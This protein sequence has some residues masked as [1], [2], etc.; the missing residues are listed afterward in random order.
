[1]YLW[2]TDALATELKQ[3][4]L[5]QREQF[6]YYFFILFLFSVGI[7]WYLM[8][9]YNE[10]DKNIESAPIVTIDLTFAALYPLVYIATLYLCYWTNRNGDNRDFSTRFISLHVPLSIKAI[11]LAYAFLPI[12]LFF[13]A[14]MPNPG[15]IPKDYLGWVSIRFGI[16]IMVW[17]CWRLLYWFRW[18]SHGT[19]S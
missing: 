2:K 3:G 1:M 4:T 9:S 13:V 16:L 12:T 7:F 10:V 18:I 11:G 14:W 17:L 15:N 8:N 6:K 5:S 19:T